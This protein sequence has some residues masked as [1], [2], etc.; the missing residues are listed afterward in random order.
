MRMKHPRYFLLLLSPVTWFKCFS[1]VFYRTR[2]RKR[3]IAVL[4]FAILLMAVSC[5]LSYVLADDAGQYSLYLS[6]VASNTTSMIEGRRLFDDLIWRTVLKTF[7]LGIIFGLIQAC[8][9]FLAAQWRQQLCDHFQQLL[10]RSP[11][12]CVLYDMVQTNENIYKVITNDIKQFTSSFASILFGCLFF[13]SIISMFALIV[14]ACVFILRAANGNANGILICFLAFIFCVLI[15]L[16]SAQLYSWNLITQSKVKGRLRSYIQRIQSHAQCI[17]LY[18]SQHVEL[19][20][21]QQLILSICNSLFIGSISFILINFP[22]QL[23]CKDRN[24]IVSLYSMSCVFFSDSITGICT[25]TLPS[26]VFF[27]IQKVQSPELAKNLLSRK[28]RKKN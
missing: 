5:Y 27:F 10:I 16:P 18:G 6:D 2:A 13:K 24:Q 11:N 23:S 14:T 4:Q 1:L 17:V 21:I 3:S 12:E 28:F 8:T 19:K 15:G 25:Y 20:Y 22:I 26:I 9:Y 7:F